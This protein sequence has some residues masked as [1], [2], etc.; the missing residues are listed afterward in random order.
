MEKVDL[1]EKLDRLPMGVGC[2]DDVMGG[3]LEPRIITEIFGEGG[4][5]KSNI[6]MQFTLSALRSG[7]SVIFL[8]TEGF[9]TERFMQICGD[10]SGLVNNLFLYRIESLDDQEVAI[11]RAGKMLEKNHK[12]TLLV[13]DS[14]TEYF[15]LEKTGDSSA[16]AAGFQRQLSVLSNIALKYRIPVLITNQIYQ[17]IDSKSLQPFGGFIID[18]TMK[19]IFKVEKLTSGKRRISVTK[20]RSLPEGKQT[21]FRIVDFGIQ[22]EV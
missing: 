11:M 21:S 17:D 10:Q 4:S 1:E 15:R 2:I 9:S 16:R 3:G 13:V 6:S 7:G 18:H 8:D 19:A 5:G 22:C 14:F 20:H 12:I